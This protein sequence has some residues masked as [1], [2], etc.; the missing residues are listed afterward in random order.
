[1]STK[2]M[3]R[4][5]ICSGSVFGRRREARRC[6]DGTGGL[7]HVRFRV[8]V[9]RLGV[10]PEEG[11]RRSWRLRRRCLLPDLQG[12]HWV[13]LGCVV[14]ALASCGRQQKRPWRLYQP[15][16]FR[17]V[18]AG[19]A[20]A[21]RLVDSDGTVTHR[22]Q[23]AKNGSELVMEGEL[24]LSR[25]RALAG[26]RLKQAEWGPSTAVEVEISVRG[27]DSAT[28]DS[29]LHRVAPADGR[30]SVWLPI[31]LKPG[32]YAWRV[33]VTVEPPLPRK[34][35][36]L[37]GPELFWVE[38]GEP[39]RLDVRLGGETRPTLLVTEGTEVE[40]SLPSEGIWHLDS[41]V[42]LPPLS[43]RTGRIGVVLAQGGGE[44]LL[45]VLEATTRSW[46]DTTLAVP[47]QSGGARLR[48][49]CTKGE[50][51]LGAPLLL[52]EDASSRL[53]RSPHSVL[54]ISLDTARADHLAPWGIMD[55]A[56]GLAS[57]A[58]RGVAFDRAISQAPVT[59]SSHHS[60]FT[61][62]QVPRHGA[63]N[64]VP[65]SEHIPS[66]AS[67][68]AE[69]GYRTAAFTDGGLVS[70]V[71]GFSKGF[72]R[73]WDY[74]RSSR[75]KAHI[76]EI[77]GRCGD[78][79]H[80]VHPQPWF[81]FVHTYQAHAPYMNHHD[82]AAPTVMVNPAQEPV[83][84][85]ELTTQ[86]GVERWGSAGPDSRRLG[87]AELLAIAKQNYQSEIRYLD[88]HVSRFLTSLGAGG[89]LENAIVV[90]VSDHGE[91]FFEHGLLSHNNSLFEELIH[92]PLLIRFP[93]DVYAGTRVGHVVETVDILPTVLE[94][95]EL[96]VPADIDGVSL[97]EACRT[98]RAARKPALSTH[99]VHFAVTLWPHKL[100]TS[101]RGQ[102]TRLY[103]LDV[104]PLE[105]TDMLHLASES[106][107]DSLLAP[108]LDMLTMAHEGQLLEVTR[109]SE[110]GP[111]LTLT[112]AAARATERLFLI[113]GDVLRAGGAS[114]SLSLRP[115]PLRR[116]VLLLPPGETTE[117]AVPGARPAALHDG[118]NRAGPFDIT[119]RRGLGRSSERAKVMPA[120]VP[121]DL[122][123]RLRALGYAE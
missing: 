87:A 73:Y 90:I 91:G 111:V 24:N 53:T 74:A 95:L 78:W 68:L 51:F 23:L 86:V 57:F 31:R 109:P 96:D 15:G 115:S 116:V 52:A 42:G 46:R 67:I 48:F 36:S 19:P 77:L 104:D 17:I 93:G 117:A 120:S 107:L 82:G 44:Q 21:V 35:V 76:E 18:S 83:E 94:Y 4:L 61:G 28:P 69:A 29:Q 11:V 63:V 99:A 92:V 108:L 14:L 98:G 39:G 22:T 105:T 37:R 25:E 106:L 112:G 33:V 43:C 102:G 122:A 85:E 55:L 12:F 100:I 75:D 118:H 41:G 113:D 84:L 70:A 79:L 20:T 13:V 27:L 60:I 71:F 5:A 38:T 16:C 2:G 10:R 62:L 88:E 66:L 72:E 65:P 121:S 3:L 45:G 7:A 26:M 34:P 54:L 89:L 49:T 110:T 1:M 97:L 56:P 6:M 9:D 80:R 114:L 123:A 47:I 119:L 59:E 50:A 64:R 30:M 58:Q 40:C 103:R 81:A 8:R 32:G 101:R